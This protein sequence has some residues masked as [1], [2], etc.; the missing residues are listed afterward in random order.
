MASNSSRSSSTLN[1]RSYQAT[2]LRY[3]G[4]VKLVVQIQQ[5]RIVIIKVQY[6][7]KIDQNTCVIVPKAIVHTQCLQ[8]NA[9]AGLPPP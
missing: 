4:D 1:D 7:E 2:A 8:G 5:E 6:Q 9:I 3:S